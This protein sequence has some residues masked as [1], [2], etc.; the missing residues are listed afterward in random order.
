[1]EP[2]DPLYVLIATPLRPSRSCV[3]PLSPRS[4]CKWYVR[5]S[6]VHSWLWHVPPAAL[7][8]AAMRWAWYTIWYSQIAIWMGYMMWWVTETSNLGTL[9]CEPQYLIVMHMQLL[10]IFLMMDLLFFKILRFPKRFQVWWHVW[11]ES[12]SFGV[13][14]CLQQ[15]KDGTLWPYLSLVN[16]HKYGTSTLL[17]GKLTT[18][19]H[20]Q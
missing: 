18:N 9:G 1:M 7:L 8:C 20:V 3:A 15:P 14:F 2:I 12:W 6:S 19:G 16:S 13:L 17:V 11:H 10:S 5:A 4:A